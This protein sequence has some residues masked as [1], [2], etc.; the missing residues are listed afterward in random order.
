MQLVLFDQFNLNVCRQTILGALVRADWSRKVAKRRALQASTELRAAWRL[1][2]MRWPMD[3]VVFL[4]ESAAN[5]RTGYRRFGWLPKGVSCV[6]LKETK[7]HNRWSILPALTVRGYLPDPLIIPGAM[8]RHSLDSPLDTEK[9][10]RNVDPSSE[11][12]DYKSRQIVRY[13]YG[14]LGL[15]A[16]FFMANLGWW[17]Q[18]WQA[19]LMESTRLWSTLS[20]LL[21]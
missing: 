7:W 12:R 1:K 9:L 3:R 17:T 13:R 11:D 10:L 14:I 4:D 21:T 20:A 18:Y 8:E 5:E 6:D 16:L 15:L 2:S 19:R